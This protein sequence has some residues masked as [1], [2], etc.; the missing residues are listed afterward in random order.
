MTGVRI[1]VLCVFLTPLL[2]TGCAGRQR[3]SSV[4]LVSPDAKSERADAGST[5]D[6][7]TAIRALRE[8]LRNKRPARQAQPGHP[9]VSGVKPDPPGGEHAI[10]TSGK[11]VVTTTTQRANEPVASTTTRTVNP[12]GTAQPAG[13]KLRLVVPV[14]AA[15]LLLMLAAIAAARTTRRGS[16]RH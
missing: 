7:Q 11:W 6:M 9:V 1:Y 10:G 4:P 5:R 16:Q 13:M 8:S 2:G 3:V 15:A 14:L 12:P